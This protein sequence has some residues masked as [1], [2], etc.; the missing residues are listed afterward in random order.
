MRKLLLLF[1][2]GLLVLSI[3]CDNPTQSQSNPY[4]QHAIEWPS[5]ADSPW[6]MYAHDPQHTGR[7]SYNGPEQGIVDWYTEL[8]GTVDNSSPILNSENNI[9]IGFQ[10]GD[11]DFASYNSAGQMLQSTILMNNVTSSPVCTKDNHVYIGNQTTALI[12]EGIPVWQTQLVNA[13]DFHYPALDYIGGYIY[14]ITKYAILKLD[15]DTGDFIDS[16]VC[17]I[18]SYYSGMSP[19][20]STNG[21]KLF[22]T[23]AIY[24]QDTQVWN[25]ALFAFDTTGEFLWT[26][27]TDLACQS[28]WPSTPSV[29]NGGNIYFR[30]GHD[31]NALFAVDSDGLLKWS[32][33]DAGPGHL[34]NGVSIGHNGSLYSISSD[35]IAMAWNHNGERL[36][37]FDC[38]K[39]LF[40]GTTEFGAVKHIYNTPVI[41]RQ[42]NLFFG[43]DAYSRGESSQYPNDTLNVVALRPD[44]TLLFAIH[45]PNDGKY[46]TRNVQSMSSIGLNKRLFILTDRELISVK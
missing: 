43:M 40:L 41:D 24:C 35:G 4:E 7:S 21:E 34:V 37:E 39:N 1:L 38:T 12:V 6:P 3:S 14:C 2:I 15:A 32:D 29:D 26:F 5:L 36:W 30:T 31:Q 18:T 10:H 11:Y 8:E 19:A 45:V 28:F 44:G 42:G 17:P 33:L 13:A 16:L 27:N 20:F 22:V 25:Y 23:G 9:L 46:S